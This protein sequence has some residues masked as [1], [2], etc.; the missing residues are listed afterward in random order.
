MCA[1]QLKDRE[2]LRTLC[3]CIILEISSLLSKKF[4]LRLGLNETMDQSVIENSVRRYG[5]VLRREDGHV[6]RRALDFEVEGQRRKWRP[7][8]TW[9]KQVVVECKGCFKQGRCYLSIK[10]ELLV[11]VLLL[12]LY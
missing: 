5:N 10:V 8:R 2:D 12:L 4:M 3:I 1:V 11:M 9:K 7:E 6:L